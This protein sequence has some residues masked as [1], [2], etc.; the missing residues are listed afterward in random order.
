MK[1]YQVIGGQY[2]TVWYGETNNLKEARKICKA[3]E[4][5]WDNWQGWHRPNIYKGEDCVDIISKGR[6]LTRD[7]VMVRVPKCYAIPINKT[8]LIRR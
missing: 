8:S 7:G 2:E 6:V 3:N 4:E 1:K 5:Y